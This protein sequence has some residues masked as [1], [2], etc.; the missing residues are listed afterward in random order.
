MKKH[1]SFSNRCIILR[2]F[3][4]FFTHRFS[5]E[6]AS[7]QAS[8]QTTN[9]PN[10]QTSKQANKQTSKQA[11]KQTSKQANKQTSKQANKQTS[12]QT[13]KQ[14]KTKQ[15]KTKQSKA[16][17]NK[18][19]QNKPKQNKT[20]QNKT[21]QNKHT[22][23]LLSP[24]VCAIFLRDAIFTDPT[25]GTPC[26]GSNTSTADQHASGATVMFGRIVPSR[27]PCYTG[28]IKLNYLFW[29]DQTMQNI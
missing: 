13:N 4:M 1:H 10:K 21:K 5:F 16:K 17:Q 3:L 19:K 6:Q 14:N 26:Q 29:R 23:F 12:K 24:Q 9:Q 15:N 11:N 18:T 27:G 8:K 25:N 28:V 7:K 22:P 20:K 2:C